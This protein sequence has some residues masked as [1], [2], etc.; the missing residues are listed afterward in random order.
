MTP[1]RPYLLRALYE[2]I[3]DNRL[4][5]HLLVDAAA[6]GVDVPDS[7]VR[8]GRIVLNVDPAAV[9]DLQLGNDWISFTAR[10]GGVSKNVAL[11][12]ASVLAIYARENGQGMMFSADPGSEPEPPESGGAGGAV[13][14]RGRPGLRVVK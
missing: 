1:S 11:P 2:W 14:A 10:F 7:Y 13:K 8:D 6:E 9:Q 12:V 3:T 4:T 5:P